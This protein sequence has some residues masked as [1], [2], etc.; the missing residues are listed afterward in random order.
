MSKTGF[1]VSLNGVPTDLIDIFQPYSSGTNQDTKYITNMNGYPQDL[2]GI[3]QPWDGETTQAQETKYIANGKDLSDIF[4]PLQ[5]F[6]ISSN[7]S[8][9][10]ISIP[11]I[12]NNTYTIYIGNGEINEHGS[13]SIT[14][15]K[16]INS[17]IM[18]IGGGGAGNNNAGGGG[19]TVFFNYT[20]QPGTYNIT[21]PLQNNSTIFNNTIYAN[22]GNS[23]NTT[24]SY[25]YAGNGGG[26]NTNYGMGASVDTN[27]G[28]VISSTDGTY[29]YY[30]NNN[31]TIY[32]IGGGGGG[33]NNGVY[34]GAGGGTAGY[35]YM[36][37]PAVYPIPLPV[38]IDS[39]NNLTGIGGGN[40]DANGSNGGGNYNTSGT[41]GGG[42]GGG[43]SS[44]YGG[45]GG[46]GCCAISFS[47]L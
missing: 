46:S 27:N 33:T 34:F 29:T 19:E 14:F 4:Q 32:S 3:F 16:L 6:Y 38:D 25:E 21:I 2:S 47:S 24:Q 43:T 44:T 41:F 15:T 22:G 40:N 9:I 17:T 12:V 26:S 31:V 7:T 30:I 45:S 11:P 39:V 8:N 42:G 13:V 20:F 23:G 18:L 5:L 28:Y 37:N 36:T 35:N 10:S 1:D